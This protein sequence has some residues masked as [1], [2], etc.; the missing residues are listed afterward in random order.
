[1]LLKKILAAGAIAAGIVGL[2]GGGSVFAESKPYIDR[3]TFSGHSNF[4][5]CI[6]KTGGY[7]GEPIVANVTGANYDKQ[8]VFESFAE[9]ERCVQ[10]TN[11]PNSITLFFTLPMGMNGLKEETLSGKYYLL[12]DD[13]V[14]SSNYLR[15]YGQAASMIEKTMGI[16]SFDANGGSGA[17]PVV[18]VAE[19]GSS[20]VLP[21]NMLTRTGYKFAGWNT[22]AD[23]TGLAYEDEAVIPAIAPGDLRLF[24]Q[25]KGRA[26]LENGRAVNVSLKQLANPGM[27][28]IQEHTSDNNIKAIRMADDMPENIDVTSDG[29]KI[30][31]YRTES[32]EPIYAWFDNGDYDD[33]GV[34]DGI[35][36]LYTEADVIEGGETMAY[37][38]EHMD[39]LT[40]IS[41]L[42]GWDV[43]NVTNMYATFRLMN[44]LSDI[45]ALADWDVSN[46]TDMRYVFDNV[47]SLSDISALAN[48]DTSNVVDMSDM[49][50]FDK[51]LTDISAL[52]NW[53]ISSA[54]KISGMFQSTAI[55]NVDALETKQHEGKDYVS[56]DVSSVTNMGS[57]FYGAKSLTDI[58]ALASWDTSSVS[59]MIGMFDGA[60][61]LLDIS[62][63]ATYETAR[64]Q[65]L[66]ELGRV[67]R[68]EDGR[69]V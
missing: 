16:I 44:S 28:P 7:Y 26:I 11:L 42:E 33:D 32:P 67:E 29:V 34:G 59:S 48:W 69:N 20:V 35:I 53:N 6:A 15:S 22:E 56:W 41:E 25:W 9:D 27:S 24:A 50:S 58:S 40:D 18:V 55:T 10:M 13:M 36:Y 68:D 5:I 30:S 51:V 43:S 65:R 2:L 17:V 23:G 54:T 39:A 64:R 57:I 66:C 4:D 52:A 38:F 62:A 37:M 14:M 31:A 12:L 45:S 60:S 61:S 1:M 21:K 8:I 63:I 46:V 3:H 47:K 49:F 19:I